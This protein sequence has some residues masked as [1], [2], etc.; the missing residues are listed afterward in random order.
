MRTINEIVDD[1]SSIF[2]VD[3]YTRI[4]W[5]ASVR[6][7]TKIGMAKSMF[8]ARIEARKALEALKKER[9]SAK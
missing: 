4:E 7:R 5:K 9:D 2:F 3:Y 6:S 8:Q 1:D